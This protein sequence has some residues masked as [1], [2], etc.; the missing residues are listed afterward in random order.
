MIK[1]ILITIYS[2]FFCS[3]L[4]LRR[5]KLPFSSFIRFNHKVKGADC[6]SIGKGTRIHRNCSLLCYKKNH[7]QKLEP[8]LR[9]GNN[10]YIN[11]GFI[12]LVAC[13][14]IID[15][16]VVFGHHI[17]LI[18]ENHGLDPNCLSYLDNKL[19]TGAIKVGQGAWIG[20]NVVVLPG[21]T[22]GEKSVIGAGAVVTKNIPEYSVAVGNPARVIK[23]YNF[24][25]K[26][27]EEVK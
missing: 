15:D 27:W 14:V 21:V 18:S 13:D 4:R 17:S 1:K 11:D 2:F 16:N 19:E 5:M 10:V 12:C 22:I 25:S 6:I 7:N 23:K 3:F 20:D 24:T 26:C 9:I 8:H